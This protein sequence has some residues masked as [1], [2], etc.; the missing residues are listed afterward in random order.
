MEEI[1]DTITAFNNVSYQ[2]IDEQAGIQLD[3]GKGKKAT[4]PSK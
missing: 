1:A 3:I 2:A 4:A